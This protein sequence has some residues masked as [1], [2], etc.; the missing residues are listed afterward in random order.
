[1]NIGEELSW[2]N[3]KQGKAGLGKEEVDPTTAKGFLAVSRGLDV[4]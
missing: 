3:L 1:M 2:G 4:E